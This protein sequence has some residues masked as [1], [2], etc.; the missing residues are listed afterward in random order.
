VV[1]VE[2]QDDDEL[3][4]LPDEV[5]LL[6]LCVV[7]DGV[8]V[9]QSRFVEQRGEAMF[10]FVSIGCHAIPRARRTKLAPF[11]CPQD[12]RGRAEEHRHVEVQR[13]CNIFVTIH[14]RSVFTRGCW[15]KVA[16]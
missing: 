9:L 14:A 4:L 6:G 2:F 8:G 7:G 5:K 13:N 10:G 11:T 3:L 12:N 15:C 16:S 1:A